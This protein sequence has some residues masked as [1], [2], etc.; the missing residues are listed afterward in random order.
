MRGSETSTRP[1]TGGIW[2]EIGL[3]DVVPEIGLHD[4]V[5]E[6]GLH[7]VVALSEP[8]SSRLGLSHP[9]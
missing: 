8:V 7:D 6:I 3:H 4:V 9:E 1:G 5:A 2:A